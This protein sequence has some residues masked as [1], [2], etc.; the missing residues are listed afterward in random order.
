ML[1]LIW[2]AVFAVGLS[3]CASLTDISDVIA[4]RSSQKITRTPIYVYKPDLVM[5]VGDKAFHDGT[6]VV[7]M[8][9]SGATEIQIW[10]MVNVDR[11]E[12]ET[13][14]RHDVCQRKG[15]KLACRE[16][17][18]KVPADW[19]GNPGKYMTYKFSPSMKEK[20]HPCSNMM[21]SIF[22]KNVLAAW[23][24]LVFSGNLDS[25]PSRMSCNASDMN[26]NQGVSV[27][28][29]KTGTIQ[30]INFDYPIDNFRASESCSM[31]KTVDGEF[32]FKPAIG[33]CQ[34]SFHSGKKKHHVIING[35][36][37]VLIR[38]AK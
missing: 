26:F 35:Y 5:Q 25:F 10:S 27:C 7:A 12:V 19:F 9:V 11:V 1:K 29:A 31:K 3:S 17:R 8:P 24:F 30:Q 18:F 4:G 14:S 33:W 22:D 20:E 15:G 23:S 13:C 6:G 32:E 38:E 16:D 36:D 2:P 28:S 21:I 37:E 34:A